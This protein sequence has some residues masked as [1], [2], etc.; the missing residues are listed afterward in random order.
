MC[1]HRYYERYGN[2]S[3]QYIR[4]NFNTININALRAAF[5]D[6]NDEELNMILGKIFL[7]LGHHFMD[8]HNFDRAI[9]LA[10]K[11]RNLC[12]GLENSNYSSEVKN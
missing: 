9:S 11:C 5:K 10:E 12:S 8:I 4:D 6:K 3:N 1:F 2:N 7:Y